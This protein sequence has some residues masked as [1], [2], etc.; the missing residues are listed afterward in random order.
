M[1]DILNLPKISGVIDS[2][3]ED[4][5]TVYNYKKAVRGDDLIIDKESPVVNNV[6]CR[7][8]YEV[9]DSPIPTG[10]ANKV[11]RVPLII[12]SPVHALQ[13]GQ[14]AV[15]VVSRGDRPQEIKGYL[16]EPKIYSHVDNQQ[17]E[18]LERRQS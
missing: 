13:S 11:E 1:G 9:H 12:T 6:P 16:G 5:L 3:Y 18:I 10:T 7:L 2:L 15:V 4:T 17:V 8:S 14:Y